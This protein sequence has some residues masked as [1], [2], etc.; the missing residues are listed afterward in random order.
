MSVLSVHKALW[1]KPHFMPRSNHKI[2][3]AVDNMAF[4][5]VWKSDSKIWPVED[6]AGKQAQRRNLHTDCASSSWTC[7][8]TDSCL[9]PSSDPQHRETRGWLREQEGNGHKSE[10]I[11]KG[12]D[13]AD[14]QQ[15]IGGRPA[16][17]SLFTLCGWNVILLHQNLS[18][19]RWTEVTS[20]LLVSWLHRP[21][22]HRRPHLCSS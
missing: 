9:S 10:L 7:P 20:C 17:W 1:A 19:S 14:T 3:M 6:P 12:E 11:W 5:I 8:G 18:G 22:T 4:S 16:L 2:H 13:E 15:S 21:S